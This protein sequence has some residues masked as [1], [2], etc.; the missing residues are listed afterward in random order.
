[1]KVVL[2]SPGTKTAFC[3]RLAQCLFSVAT[4]ITLVVLANHGH[5]SP[6]SAFNVLSLIMAVQVIWSLI[7]IVVEVWARVKNKN[8]RILAIVTSFA[9]FDGIFAVLSL[10]GA[11]ASMA[12]VL[13]YSFDNNR[14]FPVGVIH[15]FKYQMTV[16]FAFGSWFFTAWSAYA[17][18]FMVLAEYPM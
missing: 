18:T 2:G 6:N 11:S 9:V 5:V 10:A 13:H 4:I 17:M 3:L 14:C 12:I 7:V 15:C 8:L 1:M 16:V